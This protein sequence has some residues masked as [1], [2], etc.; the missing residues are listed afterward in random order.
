MK[1]KTLFLLGIMTIG[2][3][4][5]ALP[6]GRDSLLGSWQSPNSGDAAEQQA[7]AD[8]LGIAFADLTLTDKQD[9]PGGAPASQNP[10]TTDQWYLDVAPEAPGYFGIKFGVGGISVTSDTFFFTNIA[11]LTK[12]VWANEDVDY[13]SGGDCDSNPSKCNI[14]RLSHYALFDGDGVG[15]EGDPDS[16]PVPAPLALM[17]LG[18]IG[19]MGARKFLS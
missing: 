11:E 4:A 13:I 1:M 18:L 8:L 19:L 15:G 10:G 2:T 16:V 9:T 6:Y 3:A 14:G 7:L 17:G 12:L 5:N